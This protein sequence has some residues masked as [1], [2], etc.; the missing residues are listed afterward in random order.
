MLAIFNFF[1][2]IN[3]KGSLSFKEIS[4]ELTSG[5][6]VGIV[7]LPLAIAFA[8]ASGLKPEQGIYTAIV[9]GF[10]ISAFGGSKV[11]IGGP[12]GAFIIIILGIV[13][14]YGYSG[15]AISTLMA[16]I[17]LIAFGVFKLGSVI[18]YIPYPLTIGF[19][20]GIAVI[21]AFS[22]LNDFFG[23]TIPDSGF[24]LNNVLNFSSYINPATAFIGIF[25]IILI[26]VWQNYNKIIPG[27]V[28]AIIATS[29]IVAIFN[30]NTPTIGSRF[31]EL[32]SGFP[33]PAIPVFDFTKIPI[34][35]LIMPAFTIAMLGAIESLL[36]AVVADGMTGERHNSNKELIAQGIANIASPIFGGIPATGAIA[37]TATNIKNGGRTPLSGIF[38]SFVLL[39]TLLFLGKLVAFIPLAALSAILIIVAYHM[40]NISY[41]IRLFRSPKS[42]VAVLLSTFFTTI[43]FDLTTAILVGLI[44][45]TFLFM[46]RM[47][48][49]THFKSISS[50]KDMRTL[51]RPDFQQIN[52]KNIPKGVFVFEIHGPFFFGAA[53]KFK[54][55][56]KIVTEKPKV[57]LIRMGHVPAIDA[58]GIRAFEEMIEKTQK[59]KTSIFITG[60]QPQVERILK[61][62]KIIDKIGVNNVFESIEP[63]LAE[64]ASRI[65]TYKKESIFKKKQSSTKP[66]LNLNE[67]TT[68]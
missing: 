35:E 16:G 54:D 42:D 57:L 4:N 24:N 61:A 67:E 46:K 22:Q 52:K 64:A 14:K 15:L 34:T 55:T 3:I 48:E 44:L 43:F 17:M 7:A 10:I 6:I 62:S 60:M 47:T 23:I 31:G 37:R 49:V 39:C 32:A 5:F 20:S 13:Q 18:K 51:K 28:I 27:S 40:S 26:I 25:S 30:I 53:N 68:T 2:S 1:K 58:T 12:T 8:I 45:S 21:I 66:A 38:H 59:D 11:Q 50:E 36:S 65:K 9:A 19:T 33:M 29:L 56:L 63:A 41:F